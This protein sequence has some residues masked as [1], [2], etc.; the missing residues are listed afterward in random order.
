MKFEQRINLNPPIS[1]TTDTASLDHTTHT[2]HWGGDGPACDASDVVSH[3]AQLLPKPESFLP[4]EDEY[5]TP[6][7]GRVFDED[8]KQQLAEIVNTMTGAGFAGMAIFG[9]RP[10]IPWYLANLKLGQALGNLRRA[11]SSFEGTAIEQKLSFLMRPGLATKTSPVYNLEG[12]KNHTVAELDRLRASG[13]LKSGERDQLANLVDTLD[14]TSRNY[15]QLRLNA[16]IQIEDVENA[17]LQGKAERQKLIPL[18][19]ERL[20]NQARKQE[21]QRHVQNRGQSTGARREP[22]QWKYTVREEAE[23]KLERMQEELLVLRGQLQALREQEQH[24]VAEGHHLPPLR[25]DVRLNYREHLKYRQKQITLLRRKV[26]YE[27]AQLAEKQ[28]QERFYAESAIQ[29]DERA[30][31]RLETQVLPYRIQRKQH[32]IETQEVRIRNQEAK[33]QEHH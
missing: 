21:P 15:W 7:P 6:T 25:P 24:A 18:D 33:L 17:V 2:T 22:I 19:R 20:A 5:F 11:L 32:Q 27:K 4:S 3:A 31:A 14:N 1:R 30:I 29:R 26:Q 9:G 12:W 10:Q 16:K 8:D 13:A 23:I 28:G